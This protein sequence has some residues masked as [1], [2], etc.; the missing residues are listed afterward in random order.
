MEKSYD[1]LGGDGIYLYMA[2]K[3]LS[4]CAYHVVAKLGHFKQAC[5][6]KSGKKQWNCNGSR[7]TW[8]VSM[9]T[10][11]MRGICEKTTLPVGMKSH[12]ADSL[13]LNGETYMK[14]LTILWVLDIMLQ[15]TDSARVL[16]SQGMSKHRFCQHISPFNIAPFLFLL[17]QLLFLCIS[18][19]LLLLLHHPGCCCWGWRV[20]AQVF[21]HHARFFSGEESCVQCWDPAEAAADESWWAAR[22]QMMS[23]GDVVARTA[24]SRGSGKMSRAPSQIPWEISKTDSKS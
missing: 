10:A 7:F 1:S 22:V 17:L 20:S 16:Q 11:G 12:T 21:Q 5:C 3:S 4:L 13:C 2:L 14:F 18:Y 15:N 8:K 23:C 19:W 9:G 6:P 24:R